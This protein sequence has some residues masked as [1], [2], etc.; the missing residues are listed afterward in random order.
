[1]VRGLTWAWGTEFRYEKYAIYQGEDASFQSFHKDPIIYP[2]LVG[3]GNYDSSRAP[4]AGA[5]GFPGFSNTDVVSAHRT[6][7]ALYAD[8]ALDVTKE[9][10]ID[11]AVRYEHYSDFGSVLTGKLAT[12]IKCRQLQYKGFC[13]HRF[14]GTVV[15]ANTFQ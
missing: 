7:F 10:L 4:A 8:A 1:M 9:W 6:N 11:G 3:D 12:V 14:Q 15:S 2:S 5:Q 13:K